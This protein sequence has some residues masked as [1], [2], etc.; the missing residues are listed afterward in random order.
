M[1]YP[2]GEIGPIASTFFYNMSKV[3]AFPTL[4]LFVQGLKAIVVLGGI[5]GCILI[6]SFIP[7]GLISLIGSTVYGFVSEIIASITITRKESLVPDMS[8]LCSF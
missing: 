5:L 3:V 4:D 1:I 7:C 8:H 2:S 6:L